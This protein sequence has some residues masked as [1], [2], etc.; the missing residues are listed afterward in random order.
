ME[1][2]RK[3]L[4]VSVVILVSS[5]IF[6][7]FLRGCSL[8]NIARL[9]GIGIV[10]MFAIDVIGIIVV[11]RNRN[12]SKPNTPTTT[13]SKDLLSELIESKNWALSTATIT[14][15]E[16]LIFRGPLYVM[17]ILELPWLVL[18]LAIT[19]DGI[20][21]GYMHFRETRSLWDFFFKLGVGLFLCWLVI[22]SSSVVPSV[23][24]HLFPNLIWMGLFH[25]A[26]YNG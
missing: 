23:F 22:E 11:I 13:K 10:A 24:S 9:A 21:F 4:I 17:V 20:L 3:L 7:V 15:I 14:L 5:A 18:V 6:D 25:W 26:H 1:R 19:I 2:L 8:V 12:L 16:E